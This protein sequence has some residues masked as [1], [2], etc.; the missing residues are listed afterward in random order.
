MLALLL[1]GVAVVAWWLR[2]CYVDDAFTG[3][4]Y[5]TNL[6]AGRGFVFHAGDPPVEGVT[7]I[8]WLLMLAPVSALC[9][10]TFAAKV[11]G[12][13]LLS[14]A[15]PHHAAGQ[16]NLAFVRL[17]SKED[18]PRPTFGRWCPVGRRIG[19][20]PARG[21]LMIVPLIL[22][23]VSFDFTYFSLAGM[24]TAF[25]AVILLMMVWLALRR[26]ASLA[27]PI[28]GV[29]AFLVHPEAVAVYPIY[30]L[31]GIGPF[32]AAQ[33]EQSQTNL[34]SVFRRTKIGTVPARRFVMGLSILAVL[35]GAITVARYAYFHDVL[36]NTFHSKPSGV[37]Q[38]LENSSAFLVGPKHEYSLLAAWLAAVADAVV[39]CAEAGRTAPAAARM[40]AAIAVTGIAMAIYSKPDWTATGALLRALLAGHRAIVLGGCGG[41][42][43]ASAERASTGN[44]TPNRAGGP[45]HDAVRHGSFRRCSP[46]A[47][48]RLVP[49]LCHDRQ[50]LGPARNLG[51]QSPARQRSHRHTADRRVELLLRSS[52]F[53]LRVRL[54]GSRRRAAGRRAWRLVRPADRFRP[55]RSVAARAPDYLLEDSAIIDAIC[56]SEG[57]TPQRFSIHGLNYRVIRQ[58][59]IGAVA[60]WVL[61]ARLPE[62]DAR[63]CQPDRSLTVGV[64]L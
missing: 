17:P 29:A 36:P 3:L 4:Q 48:D 19:T 47:N 55:G 40:L 10:P 22:L 15:L 32:I 30:V 52:D 43:P 8:G 58:F 31:L 61:A 50:P 12:L 49:R 59:P 21:G 7:N 1:V 23:A 35:V 33:A 41:S 44:R 14:A 62:T 18:S 11:L 56:K 6:L 42:D 53:R 37:L 57:G 16:K 26:P 64:G 2:E 27:L 60:E 46:G 39:W 5:L 45:C 25:L 54:A 38:A 63:L 34:R 51:A 13:F 28:L 24:E 20:V 9:G